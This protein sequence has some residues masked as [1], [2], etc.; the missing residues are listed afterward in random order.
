MCCFSQPVSHVSSTKIFARHLDDGDQVLVYSM[1]FAAAGELAMILPLPVPPSPP[2]DA[3]RFVS[4][5]KYD[6][7]FDDMRAAFPITQMLSFSGPVP[8]AA[9]AARNLVVHEVGDFEA[10][11][12]PTL[13]DFARLDERFQLDG[14]V[15]DGLPQYRDWGFAVFKLKGDAQKQKNVHPMAFMFPRR[16]P[17]SLFFPTVHVHDGVVHETADFDH[18]LYCQP[19]RETAANLR[20]ERSAGGLGDTVD[21][22]R[23]RNLIDPRAYAFRMDLRG[24]APNGDWVLTP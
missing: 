7:F 5:E 19:S 10:S 20:W 9:P 17:T 2:E 18:A 8:S 12:V 4:L 21:A 22:T 13:P 15:W 3:V 24:T 14:R 6:R 11:F 1:R 23:A 16:D